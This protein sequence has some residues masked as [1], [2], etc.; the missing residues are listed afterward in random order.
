MKL[1][2]ATLLPLIGA[3]PHLRA[4]HDFKGMFKDWTKE[5]GKEYKTIKEYMERLEIWTENH[6]K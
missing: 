6:C 5:F 3:S 4:P 1:L 2:L